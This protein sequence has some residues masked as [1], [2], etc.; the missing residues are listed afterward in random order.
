MS[1]TKHEDPSFIEIDEK[2]ALRFGSAAC[3][4]RPEAGTTTLMQAT[5]S[6]LEAARAPHP[7]H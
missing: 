4:G 6:I 3:V 2:A 5:T 7:T 1:Q